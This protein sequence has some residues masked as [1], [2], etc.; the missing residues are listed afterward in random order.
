MTMVNRGVVVMLLLLLLLLPLVAVVVGGGAG[1][2]GGVWVGH[3]HCF[4]KASGNK[5]R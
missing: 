1:E 4:V 5:I 2:C 3:S